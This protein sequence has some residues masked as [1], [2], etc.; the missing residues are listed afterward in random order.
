MR[1]CADAGGPND[2]STEREAILSVATLLVAAP[3]PVRHFHIS[4]DTT[5]RCDNQ[6]DR[7]CD[8]GGEH[9]HSSPVWA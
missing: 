2:Q 8:T 9:T 7:H 1:R 3:L 4:A 5:L 6:S